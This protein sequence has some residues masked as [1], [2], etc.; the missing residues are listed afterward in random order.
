MAPRNTAKRLRRLRLSR[1]VNLPLFPPYLVPVLV[2]PGWVWFDSRLGRYSL[3][4]LSRVIDSGTVQRYA[5]AVSYDV[6][7]L[8]GRVT[9]VRNVF[10][11]FTPL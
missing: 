9:A 3:L 11:I 2:A 4:D 8:S 1:K 10:D 7:P 6:T 5:L